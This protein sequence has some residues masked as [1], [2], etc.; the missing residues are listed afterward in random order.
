MI[1]ATRRN[2][3]ARTRTRNSKTDARRKRATD[4]ATTNRRVSLSV[5]VPCSALPKPSVNVA[6]CLA[7]TIQKVK[8]PMNSSATAPAGLSKKNRMSSSVTTELPDLEAKK[9]SRTAVTGVTTRNPSARASTS[10]ARSRGQQ[11]RNNGTMPGGLEFID[12]S[13]RSSVPFPSSG[14]RRNLQRSVAESDG[15]PGDHF[16]VVPGR[17]TRHLP[18]GAPGSQHR[19]PGDAVLR[20]TPVRRTGDLV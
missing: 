6:A 17:V 1:P 15:I 20:V 18:A 7:N 14:G 11:R 4:R 19:C 2:G 3:A 16:F 5:M 12:W 10:I 13:N 8:M 9:R